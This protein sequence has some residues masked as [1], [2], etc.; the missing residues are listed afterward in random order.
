[1]LRGVA[2]LA[3]VACAS[4][5]LLTQAGAQAVP[6]LANGDFESGP[7]GWAPP[8]GGTLAID[9]SQPVNDGAAAGHVRATASGTVTIRTQ[10][11]LTAAT[12]GN[13]YS[14]T[15]A[16][17]IPAATI[18]TVTAR[19]DLVDD[20]GVTLATNV[21]SRSG[22]TTGYV[23]LAT[24]QAIAPANTAYVLVVV[25]GLATAPAARF[26]VDDIG[27]AEVIPPPPPPPIVEPVPPPDEPEGPPPVSAG[28]GAPIRI[29]RVVPT[30]TPPPL[31]RRLSN[32]TFDTSLDGWTVARGRAWTD[33]VLPGAGSSMVL[34]APIAGTV[35]VEQAIGGIQPGEWYQASARL[36]TRGIVDAGWLRI[37]WYVTDE[38]IGSAITTDDSL[39]V[40]SSDD[41]APAEAPRSQVVGTGTV[42]APG[43]AH[44]AI[45]RVLMRSNY[46]DASLIMDDLAFGLTA[47][48]DG[49]EPR[50]PVAATLTPV[51]TATPGARAAAPDRSLATPAPAAGERDEAPARTASTP[52]AV[53]TQPSTPPGLLRSENVALP[54]LADS[55][56]M[57]RITQLLPDPANAGRD[58]EYEWLE[59]SNLGVAA[60]SLEGMSIRD[61]SGAVTLP[62]LVVPAGGSLVV[63][64]RLAEVPGVTAFR[65]AQDIGNGLGN[66][67]DRIALIGADGRAVDALSY[68]DD[69]TY[70]LGARIPA[71]G[72]GRAI[73]RR[74]ALDGSFRD[75]TILEV[76][77]PG[78]RPANGTALAAAS[79]AAAA[80]HEAGTAAGN[81]PGAI[82]AWIVLLSLGA[83]L[84]GGGVAQR[85]GAL[86]REP[87]S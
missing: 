54:G 65:L 75:A 19:L 72:T 48:P 1:M 7:T 46:R 60:A 47:E 34:Y 3:I 13:R 80:P 33:V 50:G 71:P 42:R 32:G 31:P 58:N 6:L 27:I 22:T 16:V 67:G 8:D 25:S 78:R 43:N 18:T 17:N 35:W 61:N 73:E 5:A 45:V 4:L 21:T 86:A 57:L 74:F 9:G 15:L 44:S 68:G 37:A 79:G 85:L 81:G 30:P 38:P 83:G 41:D 20:S 63:T 28:A 29:P 70:L 23:T 26:S 51:A 11:W 59:I 55:Q 56:R 87:R 52:R 64:A 53:A 36:S 82:S 77:T 39:A 84:L 40:E 69:A 12:P 76:P 24:T 49:I 10:Y 14:M 62:A 66:A 2:A